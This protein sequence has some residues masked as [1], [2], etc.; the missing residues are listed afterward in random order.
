MTAIHATKAK[1]RKEQSG[2]DKEIDTIFD[3]RQFSLFDSYQEQDHK[4]E[5]TQTMEILAAKT[6]YNPI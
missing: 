4:Q 1:A 5:T 3:K 6:S 2:P